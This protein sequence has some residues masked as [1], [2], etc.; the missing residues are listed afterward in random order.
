M[1]VLNDDPYQNI[2]NIFI[3]KMHEQ[4]YSSFA[5]RALL[6]LYGNRLLDAVVATSTA[7]M[8]NQQAMGGAVANDS[9]PGGEKV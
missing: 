7:L 5:N 9:A 1:A 2:R 3:A 4:G 8:G 6:L